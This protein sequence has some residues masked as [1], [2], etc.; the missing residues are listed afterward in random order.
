MIV[1]AAL[2]TGSVLFMFRN[3][4]DDLFSDVSYEYPFVDLDALID[5][6][7]SELKSAVSIASFSTMKDEFDKLVVIPDVHGD[8]AN[9]MRAIWLGLREV[10]R[11]NVQFG[12]F[13][14]TMAA[15]AFKGVF[16]E[17]PLSSSRTLMV[18]IGDLVDRGPGSVKCLRIMWVVE[19]VTGWRVVYLYGNHELMSGFGNDKRYVNYK[20]V[21]AFGSMQ[22]RYKAFKTGSPL[23][24]M[25]QARSVGMARLISPGSQRGTLLVHGG[26]IRCL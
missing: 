25:L 9:F 19:G 1:V 6:T 15:A 4:S 11:F 5:F 8:V 26:W 13:A 7:Y 12:N 21:E 24:D 16:P 18:Q 14:Q 20:D 10:D 23:G 2:A 22:A 3:P 17:T